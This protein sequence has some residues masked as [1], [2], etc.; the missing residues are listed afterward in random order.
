M[1]SLK[2]CFFY[3]AN[4][5][6]KWLHKNQGKAADSATSFAKAMSLNFCTLFT[7]GRQHG[8]AY[9]KYNGRRNANF[10]AR[11]YARRGHVYCQTWFEH[12]CDEQFVFRACHD[13]PEDL[14][15]LNWMSDLDIMSVEFEEAQKLRLLKPIK[16]E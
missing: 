11:E 4:R 9:L 5:G 7:W 8:Y 6:G 3:V 15:F 2:T 12:G 10:L 13:P 14:D 16:R 1:A